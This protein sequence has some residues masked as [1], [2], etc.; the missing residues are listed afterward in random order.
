MI[1]RQRCGRIMTA[2]QQCCSGQAAR[3]YTALVLAAAACMSD[4]VLSM[5]D[6]LSML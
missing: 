6:M 1:R 4:A 3:S 5:L 2:A